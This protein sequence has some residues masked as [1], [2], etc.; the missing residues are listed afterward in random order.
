MRSWL[1]RRNDL[2]RIVAIGAVLNIAAELAT[3]TP[4]DPTRSSK[5]WSQVDLIDAS[6]QN[7][8]WKDA[9][10]RAGRLTETIL[11]ESLRDRELDQTLPSRPC[12]GPLP[13]PI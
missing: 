9:R 4:S 2:R 12:T 11:E 13:M 6:L 8:R 1:S 5:W 7:G 10:K 3:A